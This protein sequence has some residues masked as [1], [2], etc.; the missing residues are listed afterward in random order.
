MVK[1]L[2]LGV[3]TRVCRAKAL[4]LGASKSRADLSVCGKEL[5]LLPAKILTQCCVFAHVA[6]AAKSVF[7]CGARS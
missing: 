6:W 1:I 3:A 5:D 2:A 4:D 7:A